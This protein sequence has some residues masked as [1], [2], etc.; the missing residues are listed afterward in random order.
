MGGGILIVAAAAINRFKKRD[1]S[2][3]PHGLAEIGH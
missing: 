3:A 1:K 2:E